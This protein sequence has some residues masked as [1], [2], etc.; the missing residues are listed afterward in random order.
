MSKVP[1]TSAVFHQLKQTADLSQQRYF[2]FTLKLWEFPSYCASFARTSY[3]ML[4][5]QNKTQ[6]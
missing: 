4:S 5:K 2:G 6:M 1:I 3:T